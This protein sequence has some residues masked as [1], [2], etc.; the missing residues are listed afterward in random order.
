M[1]NDSKVTKVNRCKL[2][3]VLPGS[4]LNPIGRPKDDTSLTG[5]LRQWL[6]G[7]TADGVAN[8]KRLI[9]VIGTQAHKGKPW[10]INLILNRTDGLL[11]QQITQVTK[12]EVGYADD[13]N[14]TSEVDTLK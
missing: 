7:E 13:W 10:A 5:M 6:L 3:R 14:D 12:I 4:T 11:T 1:A 2:G 9:D 8:N